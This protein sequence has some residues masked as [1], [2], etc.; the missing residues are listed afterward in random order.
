MKI[1]AK[2]TAKSFNQ[3]VK[4]IEHHTRYRS[5]MTAERMWELCDTTTVD[6]ALDNL[7][8][9]MTAFKHVSGEYST[10]ALL[11]PA[12]DMFLQVQSQRL[13]K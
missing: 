9:Y 13:E 8:T 3:V 5:P 12:R 10:G 6:N 11:N 7:A 4:S 2:I 1:P